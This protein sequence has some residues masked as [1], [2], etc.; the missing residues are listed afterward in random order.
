M[1]HPSL[2]RVGRVGRVNKLRSLVTIFFFLGSPVF[3]QQAQ[4]RIAQEGQNVTLWSGWNVT[5]TIYVSVSGGSGSDCVELWWIT[6]GINSDTWEIC[7][8]AQIE[9]SLPLIYG[10]LRAGGFD[11]QA[12][13]AVSDSAT[14]AYSQQLCGYVIDCD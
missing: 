14:V 2:I 9:V 3:G 6:M 13:I 10:E 1:A 4:I 11:R 8:Q 12:A 7:D 5:A